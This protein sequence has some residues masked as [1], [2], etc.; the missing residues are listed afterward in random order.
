M[1][2]AH[3]FKDLCIFSV[4]DYMLND[5]GGKTIIIILAVTML[6]E[7][8][9]EMIGAPVEVTAGIDPPNAV[10]SP[11]PP[12]LHGGGG[13]GGAGASSS[14]AMFDF[15]AGPSS[16]PARP[17]NPT[18]NR[19]GVPPGKTT[20]PK[21]KTCNQSRADALLDHNRSGVPPVKTAIPKPVRGAPSLYYTDGL[22]GSS[23]DF[24]NPATTKTNLSANNKTCNQSAISR[25]D[26][27]LDRGDNRSFP[28]RKNGERGERPEKGAAAA[29][30]EGG[31]AWQSKAGTAEKNE[32]QQQQQHYVSSPFAF[33]PPATLSAM[34]GLVDA[35]VA[36]RVDVDRFYARAEKLHAHFLE[37]RSKLYNDAQC[38]AIV[39]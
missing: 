18:G 9:H 29:L 6:Q 19:S 16:Q 30:F 23:A 35:S 5:T 27:L 25:A 21:P 24:K 31:N 17:N 1:Q 20:I 10:V 38:L 33:A 4:D 7:D 36:P 32:R 13:G 11:V 37:N 15:D 26:A 28:V 12:N 8:Y 3:S 14:S 34:S 2:Q 22:G 39:R